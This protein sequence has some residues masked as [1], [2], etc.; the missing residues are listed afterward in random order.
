MP[1]PGFQPGSNPGH[2]DW[3]HS[4]MTIALDRTPC[5]QPRYSSI[6]YYYCHTVEVFKLSV[7]QLALFPFARSQ[8]AAGPLA[9]PHHSG[10]Q[11]HTWTGSLDSL[12]A[13]SVLFPAL[14][15]RDQLNGLVAQDHSI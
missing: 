13:S 15:P 7:Q 3:S 5:S 6:H 12:A 10:G 14:V 8:L 9:L 11:G 1:K 4:A 2:I